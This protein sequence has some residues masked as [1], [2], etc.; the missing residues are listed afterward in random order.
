M[1]NK[2]LFAI[3]TLVC[4]MFTLM[5]VATFA[6]DLDANQVYVKEGEAWKDKA[7]VDAGSNNILAAVAGVANE[8]YVFYAVDED[9]E[10]VAVSLDGTF[11][12]KTEDEYQI[13]AVET[14]EAISKYFAEVGSAA[15]KVAMIEDNYS[16]KIVDEYATVEVE[17]LDD[18]YDFVFTAKKVTDDATLTIDNAN[19]E[20]SASV[21]ANNGYDYVEVTVQLLNNGEKVKGEEITVAHSSYVTV[22]A[23][24]TE[25]DKKGQITYKVVAKRGG[26]VYP[27]TFKYDGYKETLDVIAWTVGTANVEVVAEPKAAKTLKQHSII[28]VLN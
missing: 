5:P 4:F 2:K 15:A 3:L 18:A 22:V 16:S 8:N 23:D 28:L 14:T 12:I 24:A 1:K 25:T 19:D 21:K 13:Y 17:A 27:I 7:T 26:D 20:Q 10:G 6:A 9:G 11:T